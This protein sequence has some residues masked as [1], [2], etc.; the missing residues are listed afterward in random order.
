[1]PPQPI[2][3]SGK[4]EQFSEQWSPKICAQMNDTHFKLVKFKG[5]FVW[6]LH[7]DTDEVFLVLSGSMSIEF[8][9]GV[10]ELQ[11]GEM[12]VVP[13]LVEHRPV[14]ESECHALVIERAG[15]VNTGSAGEGPPATTGEWI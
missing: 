9:D 8:R 3:L 5:E 6:H 15:T 11:A 13:R 7:E 12:I 4:L 1:M 14:A 2:N 10:V